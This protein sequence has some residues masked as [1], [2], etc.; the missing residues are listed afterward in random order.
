MKGDFHV[1][2]CGGLEVKLL[3]PTRRPKGESEALSLPQA[4]E[5]RSESLSEVSVIRGRKFSTRTLRLW[6][7]YARAVMT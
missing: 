3:R 4:G 2:F 1:R 5:A 7:R 6:V